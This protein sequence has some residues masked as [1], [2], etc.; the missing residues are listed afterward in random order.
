MAQPSLGKGYYRL[1]GRIDRAPQGAPLSPTLIQILRMLFSEKE[2][3]LAAQLPQRP[4]SAELAAD[5]WDL[6]INTAVII[7]ER[8]AER[9]LVLDFEIKGRRYFVFPP[10]MAGFFEFSLMAEQGN[11]DQAQ[12]ASLYYRYLDGEEE[13]LRELFATGK[14]KVGRT[15]VQETALSRAN[16]VRIMDYERTTHIIKTAS[17]IGVGNCFCRRKMELVGRSCE[18]PME[19]CLALSRTAEPLIRQGLVRLIS[20]GE[21]LDLLQRCCESNLVQF[22]ENV[23]ENVSFLCNCCCC[24]CAA[25]IAVRKFAWT[26]PVEAS[27]FIPIFEADKCS[28]CGK[29]AAACPVEALS[30]V[31]ANNPFKPDLQKPKVDPDLC[32]GCG[33]CV[34][35]CPDNLVDLTI[36]PGKRIIT[37]K[38]SARRTVLMAIERGKL[39]NL[40]FD[41]RILWSHRALAA[42]LGAFL[43]LPPLKLLMASRQLKSISVNAM[44]SIFGLGRSI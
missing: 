28:G 2:A 22:G 30:L 42:L 11:I 15:F 9:A 18:A 5:I 40:I 39:Q 14:T 16:T 23:R 24:C 44:V 20:K 1:A 38:D 7:L 35:A 25:M 12:L 32:L 41:N 31:S 3:E 4:F 26:R 6:D 13:F 27:G 37:P 19:A 10:P 33:L 21:A 43:S 36:R 29:C 34:D 17:I 8:L